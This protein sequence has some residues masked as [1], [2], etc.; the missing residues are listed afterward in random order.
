MSSGTRVPGVG[1]AQVEMILRLE[2][3]EGLPALW[4]QDVG[5]DAAPCIGLVQEDPR[6]GST[7]SVAPPWRRRSPGPKPPWTG[8]VMIKT[9][10]PF[11]AQIAFAQLTCSHACHGMPTS[12]N[13]PIEWRDPSRPTDVPLL[14]VVLT[15][16]RG[17]VLVQLVDALWI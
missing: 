3:G 6:A 8:L 17:V 10:R 9:V 13:E 5:P 15:G 14:V 1:H 2:V 7:P 11:V 16:R 12:Q 4:N